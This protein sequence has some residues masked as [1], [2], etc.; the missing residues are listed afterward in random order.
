MATILA[1]IPVW[2]VKAFG[3]LEISL[4]LFTEDEVIFLRGIERVGGAKLSIISPVAEALAL[5]M[6]G[7]RAGEIKEKIDSLKGL[8]ID[9]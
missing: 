3:G 1:A 2:R 8:S 5:I 7:R 6:F 4:L 9:V